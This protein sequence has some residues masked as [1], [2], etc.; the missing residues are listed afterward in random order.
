LL[1]TIV[2]SV[3]RACAGTIARWDASTPAVVHRTVDAWVMGSLVL[4]KTDTLGPIAVDAGKA[5]TGVTARSSA[6]GRVRAAAMESARAAGNVYAMRALRANPANIVGQGAT[7]RIARL[8][9]TGLRNAR[10]MGFAWRMGAASASPGS[11]A[12]SA[13]SAPRAS[14]ERIAM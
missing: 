5:G 14:S 6:S 9:A 8:S 12:T 11:R 1:G 10:H 3:H 7:G 4:V 2:P 13:T